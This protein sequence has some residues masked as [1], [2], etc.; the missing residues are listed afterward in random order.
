MEIHKGVINKY[1]NVLNETEVNNLINFINDMN[2]NEDNLKEINPLNNENL[3][4]DIIDNNLNIS[5]SSK[6]IINSDYNDY[7]EEDQLL[8]EENNSI[9]KLVIRLDSEKKI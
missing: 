9:L 7:S 6:M 4:E 3:S 8:C 2:I 1:S 5:G